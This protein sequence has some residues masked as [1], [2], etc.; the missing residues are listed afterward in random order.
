MENR[1]ANKDVDGVR[2][3][4]PDRSQVEMKI[5]SPDELIPRNHQARTVWAVVDTMD[6]SAFREPIKAREGVCGRDATDPRLLVSLW[7]YAIIRGVGSARE[8]GRLCT[9]SNPYQWLCGGVTVNYHLLSDFRSGHGAALD[10]LFTRS[11]ASLVKQGLVTVYRVSQDGTRVRAY[12]G[13]S[14]FRREQTLDELLAAAE[15]HVLELKAL[16]EDPEKSDFGELS[17]TAGLSSRKKA[18]RKRAAR[19][20]VERI[21][22]AVAALPDLQKRQEELSKKVAEKDKPKKLKE[23]RASTTDAEARVM[24][25]GNGGFNPAM[26]VQFAVDTQSRAIVGVDVSDRGTDTNL[27]EPMRQQVEQ[28]TGLKVAEHLVDGGY[29]DK[30]QI[31]RAAAE[32]TSLF[33]PPKPPRNKDKRASAY[34]PMPGESQVL[35]DWRAKMGSETGQSIYKERASTVETV[36]ADL[37]THR[38]M[39]RLLVRGLKKAK[40]IALWSAL[41]YNM[42]HFGQ[43]LTG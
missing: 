31:E 43:A 1:K 38:G 14:S 12:A 13:A 5:E 4:R 15:A 20:R 30:E 22:Q 6:L 34:D 17:R 18:A 26:N 3:R 32:G 42:I 41:A 19:E 8:L 27:S 39:N 11:I 28:R 25:M 37:K 36:N 9:E 2:L 29:S 40:C 24:K 23:P 16:L 7:L 33:I 10:G 35:T 21:K